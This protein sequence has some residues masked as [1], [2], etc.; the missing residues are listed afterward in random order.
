MC[1]PHGLILVMRVTTVSGSGGNGEAAASDDHD[2]VS[3]YLLVA[4][5]AS[6]H[7]HWV[8]PT[9]GA[10]TLYAGSE[11]DSRVYP[12]GPLQSVRLLSPFG[13]CADPIF[14]NAYF[15]TDCF[16]VRYSDGINISLIA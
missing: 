14:P 4:D 7:V 15:I 13:V 2:Q 1:K 11:N 12:D 9:S 3:P 8:D 10:I 5:T 6:D 16:T